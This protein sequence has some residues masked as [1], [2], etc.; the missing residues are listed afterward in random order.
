MASHAVTCSQLGPPEDLTFEERPH[1]ECGPR[2]LRL[3]VRAAGLNYVDALFVMGEYQIKPPVPFVP[4]SEV[5]GVV[6]EVGHDVEG[7]SVGDR[8][9]AS[10]G[11]G[12]FATEVLCSATQAMPIPATVTDTVAATF[13]QSYCTGEFGLVERAGLAAGDWLL[14][15]G[16]GGGVG[17]AAVDIGVSM[18]AHVIA[19]ASSAEKLDAAT[20]LGAE[21]TID[22]SV[23]DVKER[24]RELSGGGVDV[25]YD[26]V[27]GELAELGL[28]AL[29]YDGRLVV[30]GFASGEIPRLP[31][32]QI[33]LRNRR[34][35]GVDWG[36]WGMAN[37]DDSRVLLDAVLDKV[38]AGTYHPREPREYPLSACGSAMRD[39]LD[40]NLTGKAALIP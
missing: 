7:W 8:A 13:G 11:L 15:L 39:L 6:T 2:Q 14:V 5:A 18:G 25:V 37:P 4:G 36:A 10:L 24:A 32:N 3:D 12:A 22:Y 9:S 35:V 23:D 17:L 34:V 31:A 28:R 33:L 38:A 27:G 19:A 1:A 21:A 16:A 40:R 20:A 29:G 26:P 30:I